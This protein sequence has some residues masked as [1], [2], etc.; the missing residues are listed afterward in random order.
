MLKNLF[1]VILAA[2]FAAGVGYA[3]ASDAT[4]VVHTPKTAATNGKQMYTSYCASCHGIDGKG[5]G[6]TASALKTQPTDLTL[7]SKNN[8]GNFPGPHVVSVLQF[9]SNSPTH[10]SAQMPVWGP[11]FSTMNQTNSQERILRIS[12]L[13]RYLETIQAK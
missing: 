4:V 5:A 1:L 3:N 12:N 8:G 11:V 6:P 2:A 9:G 10:G 7:L 13:A